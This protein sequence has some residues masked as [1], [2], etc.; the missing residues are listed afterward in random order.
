VYTIDAKVIE[1][2]ARMKRMEEEGFNLTR[3]TLHDITRTHG[4]DH[5]ASVVDCNPRTLEQWRCG[6]R[7]MPMDI[8]AKLSHCFGVDLV[9]LVHDTARTRVEKGYTT[10]SDEWLTDNPDFMEVK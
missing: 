8:A 5:V 2:L 9:Q 10:I 6:R 7:P 3:P 1:D 4:I